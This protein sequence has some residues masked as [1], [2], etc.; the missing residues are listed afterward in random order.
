MNGIYLTIDDAPSGNFPDLCAFLK[1]H[2]IPAV[3][4]V[5]GDLAS[6]YP[7]R[8]VQAIQDGFVVANHGWSHHHASK[9]GVELTLREIDKAQAQIDVL[10]ER[11]GK[12]SNR[13]VRFPHMDA[14]LGAWPLPP[15]EFT[16]EEQERIH[17][18][19]ARFYR[20]DMTP[21]DDTARARFVAIE[22][23][24]RARG[25]RQ[26]DFADAQVP[27]YARYAASNAVS[28]QGTFCHP[29][30]YL[31]RRHRDKLPQDRDPVDALNGN[32]D[33]FM[34]A[35]PDGNHILVMHDA[36]ELWPYFPCLIGHIRNRGIPFLP[37]PDGHG[38]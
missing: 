31:N 16:P 27:W 11:A 9:L 15:E 2:A 23:G 20:N 7:D 30:W 25:Y 19:Y 13:F 5:R 3:F 6:L 24:L 36:V 18:D 26:M 14:G 8:L 37:I 32:F 12:P 28:T 1:A 10:Y 33:A 35:N 17:V 22:E 38:K 21:P 29:D 34:A 4:F